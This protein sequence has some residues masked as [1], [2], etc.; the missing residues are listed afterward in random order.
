MQMSIRRY[1][2]SCDLCKWGNTH[3]LISIGLIQPFE[4][5]DMNWEVVNMNF[6]FGLM[7]STHGH[8]AIFVCVNKFSKLDHFSDIVTI[9]ETT[10]LFHDHVYKLHG[11]P[12]VILSN[13]DTRFSSRFWN[14]LHGFSGSRLV[15][16]Y[17]FHPQTDGQT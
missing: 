13:K 14:V 7:P 1:I 16:S 11:L 9:E 17:V 10:R 3:A 8:D 2:K 5:R 4:T 15:M 6:I 12:K